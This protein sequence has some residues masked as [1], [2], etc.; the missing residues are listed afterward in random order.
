MADYYVPLMDYVVS[1]L[2][3]DASL[4]ALVGSNIFSHV[5]Q[6]TDFPYVY[7][8]IEGLPFMDKDESG[9]DFN[10]QVH[11]YDRKSSPKSVADIRSAC[12]DILNRAGVNIAL[13]SGTLID[14]QHSGLAD[15]FKDSDGV[16]WHGVI[17]FRAVV[18]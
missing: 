14:I 6:G 16:S 1:A 17:E 11:V 18:Q 8:E 15:I 12:Y 2:K 4:A 3:A 7:V 10:V 5:P 9:M 13:D